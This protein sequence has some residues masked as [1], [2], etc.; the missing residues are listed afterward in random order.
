MLKIVKRHSRMMRSGTFP[1]QH[2]CRKCRWN[3]ENYS[4]KSR[5]NNQRNLWIKSRFESELWMKPNWLFHHD[6]APAQSSI[7]TREFLTFNTMPLPIHPFIPS[8]F[9][10]FS[11]MWFFLFQKM[12]LKLK[13]PRFETIEEIDAES[14][15]V[16]KLFTAWQKRWINSLYWC[17]RRLTRGRW[18]PKC[19]SLIIKMYL[20]LIRLYIDKTGL[21]L[22][23]RITWPFENENNFCC[24]SLIK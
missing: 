14:Q 15:A 20:K 17:R 11:S 21:T 16:L 2:N 13:E 1:Y 7:K 5:I 18:N 24:F 8:L 19:N 9:T 12:K 4:S 23:P 22:P 10:G 6:K 3:L